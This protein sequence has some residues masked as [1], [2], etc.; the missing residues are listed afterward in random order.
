M[1]EPDHLIVRIEMTDLI[2]SFLQVT[3]LQSAE[4]E[5]YVLKICSAR[6]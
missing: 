6:T 2:E 4:I 3:V 5:Y 1:H